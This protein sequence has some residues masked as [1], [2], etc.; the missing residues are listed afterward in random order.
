[1]KF[2]KKLIFFSIIA[3]SAVSAFGEQKNISSIDESLMV[4]DCYLV[5]SITKHKVSDEAFINRA[6]ILCMALEAKNKFDLNQINLKV[7]IRDFAFPAENNKSIELFNYTNDKVIADTAP[8]AINFE[9]NKDVSGNEIKFVKTGSYVLILTIKINNVL[10][11]EKKMQLSIK[12]P[13]ELLFEKCVLKDVLDSRPVVKLIANKDY[14][15]EL[16]VMAMDIYNKGRVNISVDLVDYPGNKKLADFTN[17]ETIGNAKIPKIINFQTK[18]DASG[19]AIKFNW[20][21]MYRLRFTLKVDGIVIEEKEKQINVLPATLDSN[22]SKEK[23]NLVAVSISCNDLFSGRVKDVVA[24]KKYNILAIVKNDGVKQIDSLTIEAYDI[25][26]PI[27][28]TIIR[29][30]SPGKAMVAKFDNVVFNDLGNRS[31]KLVI[32]SDNQIREDNEGDNVISEEI[33]V[34]KPTAKI[35]PD[36]IICVLPGENN[37]RAVYFLNKGYD[38]K[39][40]VLNVGKVEGNNVLIKIKFGGKY[41]WK[42]VIPNLAPGQKF[43]VTVVNYKFENIGRDKIYGLIA[44]VDGQEMLNNNQI[45]TMIDVVA[46]P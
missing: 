19:N 24:G 20:P 29:N 1:M 12:E 32:D 34:V 15:L 42:E 14:S 3:F 18:R 6:Y 40:T 43:T 44:S 9:I 31:I 22:L 2:I 8:E 36:S 45:S 4:N 25:N 16:S 10:V 37:P 41:I 23:N 7:E 35:Q 5:D 39:F 33:I 11:Q 13:I 26:K 46:A 17:N 21:G 27:G 38:I 30:I 28:R